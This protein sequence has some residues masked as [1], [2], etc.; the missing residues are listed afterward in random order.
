MPG[1][2]LSKAMEKEPKKTNYN[3]HLGVYRQRKRGQW[4]WFN[5]SDIEEIS[6]HCL[7]LKELSFS[8]LP[9][10]PAFSMVCSQFD[11]FFSNKNVYRPN[12][13]ERKKIISEVFFFNDCK[14]SWP[15]LVEL[16]LYTFFFSVKSLMRTC[17]TGGKSLPTKICLYFRRSRAKGH[18][19]E[20]LRVSF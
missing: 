13:R 20:S 16:I 5:I 12:C 18:K 6:L 8:F 7:G 15:N 14:A 17:F 3:T 11:V 2:G 19:I 10:N 1:S 4:L 9:R